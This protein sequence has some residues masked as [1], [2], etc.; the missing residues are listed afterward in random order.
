[1]ALMTRTDIEETIDARTT[2]IDRP[3]DARPVPTP[4]VNEWLATSSAIA[5]VTVTVR[6]LVDVYPNLMAGE[7]E[8][9]EAIAEWAD[10]AL[11]VAQAFEPL[12]EESWREDQ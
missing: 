6:T 1:M 2:I 9:G 12:L 4:T 11:E 8:G 5:T 10:E 7:V 3:E